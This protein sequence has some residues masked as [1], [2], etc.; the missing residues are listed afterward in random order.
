MALPVTRDLAWFGVF[1]EHN[2]PAGVLMCIIALA[3]LVWL[4]TYRG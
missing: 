4:V 2:W 1:N 3:S